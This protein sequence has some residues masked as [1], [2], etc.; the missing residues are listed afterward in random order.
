MSTVPPG[1]RTRPEKLRIGDFLADEPT[2]YVTAIYNDDVDGI[3]VEWSDGDEGYLTRPV[4]VLR[5][6]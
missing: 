4:R 1:V 6:L 5:D 3:W 2:V